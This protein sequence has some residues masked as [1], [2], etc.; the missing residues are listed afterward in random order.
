V[1]QLPLDSS[2]REGF[3]IMVYRI[4]GGKEARDDWSQK[5]L[6]EILETQLNGVHRDFYENGDSPICLMSIRDG[7]EYW[8][9]Y[10]TPE[11]TAVPEGFQHE[12]FPRMDLGVC[13]LYGKSDEIY[14]EGIE[15]TAWKKLEQEGF[16]LLPDCADWW[17]ERYAHNRCTSDKM[18]HAL[19][20]QFHPPQNT[21]HYRQAARGVACFGI[22]D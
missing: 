16:E 22:K 20:S 5:G 13:W 7:F 15:D 18:E 10:F 21:I 6:Y 4:S 12:D 3:I 11:G 19:G 2:V 8:L 1:F 17:I 9:G 14:M